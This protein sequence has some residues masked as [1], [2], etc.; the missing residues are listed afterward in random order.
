MK[1]ETKKIIAQIQKHTNAL[2]AVMKIPE[3][4]NSV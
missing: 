4:P 1:G 2:N 3:V